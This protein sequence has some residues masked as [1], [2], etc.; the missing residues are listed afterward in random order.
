MTATF[1]HAAEQLGPA[2]LIRMDGSKRQKE[3]KSET[4]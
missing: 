4:D 2:K 3:F 1:C